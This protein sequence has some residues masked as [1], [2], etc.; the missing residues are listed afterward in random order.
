[1][2][3]LKA[4]SIIAGKIMAQNDWCTGVVTSKIFIPAAPTHP[5][6]III[7]ADIF[8]TA[9]AARKAEMIPEIATGS[10]A[11]PT[12]TGLQRRMFAKKRMTYQMY[13]PR[14]M[15][16]RNRTNVMAANDG[17]FQ[18]STGMTG[19]VANRASQ[20]M[21]IAKWP[22]ATTSRTYS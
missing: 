10:Q 11:I 18:I 4:A 19:F 9:Q 22:I 13:I 3:P 8:G 6:E 2:S 20:V 15:N 1:M 21:N 14:L 17:V 7:C 16:T 12:R 5:A